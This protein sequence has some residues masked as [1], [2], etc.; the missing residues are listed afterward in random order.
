MKK[1]V[2]FCLFSSFFSVFGAVNR[3]TEVAN[4]LA[5]SGIIDNHANNPSQ[6]NLKSPILRQ[7][8]VGMALRMMKISLPN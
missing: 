7:E 4:L 3:D 2:L 5:Q 6:Y 8:M 1:I